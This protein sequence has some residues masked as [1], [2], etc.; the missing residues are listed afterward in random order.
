MLSS[1][2]AA[3]ARAAERLRVRSALNPMLWVT[4]IVLPVC[5][6][7]A[8][9]FRDH[10]VAVAVLIGCGVLTV[11]T[12]CAGFGYFAK[13][14]PEMLQSEDWQLRHEALQMIQKQTG[15]ETI[16]AASVAAIANPVMGVLPA[17]TGPKP[18][19]VEAEGGE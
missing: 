5:V 14:K 9:L 4:A 19:D 10:P 1:L 18:A 8:F 17:A 12:T 15:H 2:T 7:G 13:T 3:T 6:G 16:D 11:V